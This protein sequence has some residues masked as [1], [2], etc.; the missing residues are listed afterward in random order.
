M[1]ILLTIVL[2]MAV[3]APASGLDRKPRKKEKKKARTE[4]VAEPVPAPAPPAAKPAH[5]ERKTEPAAPAPAPI[6]D[7]D[8]TL[9]LTAA[10]ADS[11]VAVWRE[12]QCCDSFREFFDNYIL[13]D[14]TQT[15][16][17][18][19]SVYTRRLRD[20]ASPIQLPY[21]SIVRGYI[22]RYTDSRYGT[23]SRI[24]GMSQYYFPLIEDELL[25]EGLPIELRALPIIESAL[26]VTAVSPM[27]AVGLWQFMPS[28]GKSYGLEVNS[29][30]DER[31]DP[32]RSTQA[33][34]RYLKDLYAIYKDW[35][36]A[37]AA[38]NCGPGN[39]TKAI[40]RSGG[41]TTFWGVYPYLPRETRNYIPL[42]IGAYY[43]C[44]YHNEHN[45]CP[46]AQSM[47]L[48]T[49]TLAVQ[50]PLT[51]AQISQST[52]IPTQQIRTLNPQ[53]KRGVIPAAGS[54][55]YT[56]R[57]PLKGITR[58][59]EALI[60]LRRDHKEELSKQIAEAQEEI[61][62]APA[63]TQK[64]KATRGGYKI[65]KVRRGDTL[66]KIAKRH[67]VSVAAIKRANGLKGRN[68]KLRP[69]QRLKIPK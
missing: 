3:A 55:P 2:L 9:G 19:D 68:P 65:Y 48:A 31:R 16:A 8:M 51:F 62:K 44:Y 56:I 15:G 42:F 18:P 6:P 67:G 4:A 21:N 5:T 36:L 63:P 7:N 33:A 41:K 59:D 37:I 28:T 24:L 11:L 49:D 66:A 10:Q 47:P 1:R 46:Q 14:S 30:V 45:I 69:G 39:V 34:C 58:L 17:V 22:N 61:K 60:N 43:A 50:I 52:G 32:V 54:T 13:V 38:Y 25:K 23:I 20:L 53:Y 26:S 40:R 57:L 27:G 64:S 29:L 35:S 12:R